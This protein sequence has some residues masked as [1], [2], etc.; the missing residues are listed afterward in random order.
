MNLSP[1]LDLQT[2]A[3][4]SNNATG[5]DLQALIYNA[6]IEAVHAGNF[7]LD[8]YKRI[9]GGEGEDSFFLLSDPGD[10]TAHERD[11]LSSRVRSQVRKGTI[12]SS[13]DLD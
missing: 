9:E 6:Q 12:F 8:V 7:E 4:W 13:F 11:A 1:D 2:I 5:G 3:E 10:T